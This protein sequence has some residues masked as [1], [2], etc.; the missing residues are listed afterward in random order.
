VRVAQAAE[1]RVGGDPLGRALQLAL[2]VAEGEL[3]AGDDEPDEF[4]RI[5]VDGVGCARCGLELALAVVRDGRVG[6]G[7]VLRG[8]P[9]PGAALPGQAAGAQAA[10]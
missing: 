6:T 2:G 5:G 10:G 7:Q 3:Q 4:L 9:G 8:L 1:V